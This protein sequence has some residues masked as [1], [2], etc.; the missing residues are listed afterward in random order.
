MGWNRALQAAAAG[1]F[2]L[3]GGWAGVAGP[4][5]AGAAPACVN[6]QLTPPP[7][8][9]RSNVPVLQWMSGMNQPDDLLVDGNQVLVG[10]LVSGAIDRYGGLGPIGSSDRLP[11][12]IPGVE[13]MARIGGTLYVADQPNNRVA[14]L[15]PTGQVTTF[16]QL[17]TR[18]GAEG[19]DGLGA[20][21]STLVVADSEN[22]RVLLVD[23]GGQVQRTITGFTRPTG[24]WPLQ[25]GSLLVADELAG[26]VVRVHPDGTRAIVAGGIPYADDVV[27]DNL[28]N[29]YAIS[30]SGNDVLSL[31]GGTATSVAGGLNQP[32]GLGEDQ[33]GNLYV[34]E[35]GA[36]RLDL[37]LMTFKLAPPAAAPTLHVGDLLCVHALRSPVC[38]CALTI[39]PSADFDVVQ[40]PQAGDGIVRL[41]GCSGG[42]RFPVTV[43]S[44]NESDTAFFACSGAVPSPSPS[45]APSPPAPLGPPGSVAAI[46][47]VG[48]AVVSWNAPA[49]D[50]GSPV[51]AYAVYWYPNS[52]V[53]ILETGGATSLTVSGL[54]PQTYYTF[55]VT[56]WNGRS[57]GPWAGWSQYVLVS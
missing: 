57:W 25:D 8:A 31:G 49:S 30:I 38:N 27:A 41:K 24:V 3:V 14:T 39:Q 50:G 55:T 17:Q 37:V 52:P 29:Q 56:A 35:S 36:G 1:A 33:A 54:S 2:T 32:Q 19:V 26:Q 43:T 4:A 10:E 16:L 20:F 21:G 45:L 44:G 53:G 23:Q 40:Q 47:G 22:G 46:P 6:A 51:T 7:V 34:T 13:G 18:P 5:T 48:Q 42:D 9:A 11:G 15:A 28:G 12:R